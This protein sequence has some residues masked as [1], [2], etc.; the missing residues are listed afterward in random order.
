MVQSAPFHANAGSAAHPFVSRPEPAHRL[1]PHLG[2]PRHP[3]GLFCPAG[4]APGQ[5]G[6]RPANPRAPG[7]RSRVGGSEPGAGIDPVGAGV[8]AGRPPVRAGRRLSGTHPPGG[9]GAGRCGV[10]GWRRAAVAGFPAGAVALSAFPCRA[11]FPHG[12]GHLFRA[13][14][15]RILRAASEGLC[16][17]HRHL[18]EV[19]GGIAD[20]PARCGVT[21]AGPHLSQGRPP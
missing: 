11:V 2:S 16:Q 1:R 21:P 17:G 5:M 18:P 12:R 8:G 4:L 9:R 13:G 19:A 3:F 10:P 15:G 6:G 14:G 20:E 7:P